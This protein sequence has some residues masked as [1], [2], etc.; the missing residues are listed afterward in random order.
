ML[1]LV[2]IPLTAPEGVRLH[3]NMGSLFHGS[4][5]ELVPPET[6]DMLHTM[7]LRPYSQ[8]VYW[9][10]ERQQEFWRI[11]TLNDWA[12]SQLI[13]PLK[14]QPR[15]ELK[16]KEIPV[17][18]G[19]LRLVKEADPQQMVSEAVQKEKVPLSIHWQTHS[20]MSFKQDG[21]YVI[22]PDA[23]LLVQNLLRR[24]NVFFPEVKLEAP[25]LAEQM[26]RH[27]RL[28]QYQLRSQLY[29]VNGARIYGCTG[30]M[31]YQVFGYDMLKRLHGLLAAFAEFSGVGIKTALGMGAVETD[32]KWSEAE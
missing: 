13:P 29:G 22:L 12:Y 19:E 24:W 23:Q 16:Q 27:C 8:Y 9:D 10:K 6:A 1:R 15:L 4:L 21:R 28:S 3:S 31:T 30:E 18:L 17:E 14:E 5:M 2:E 20:V 7:E 25:D 26:A 11:G 32:I